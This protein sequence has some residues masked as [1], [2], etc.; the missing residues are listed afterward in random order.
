MNFLRVFFLD[1]GIVRKRR[2]NGVVKYLHLIPAHLQQ[3]LPVASG[4]PKERQDALCKILLHAEQFLVFNV[5][6][7]SLPFRQ[8]GRLAGNQDALKNPRLFFQRLFNHKLQ[9]RVARS[10]A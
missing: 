9:L 1:P 6:S 7:K 8:H 3:D 4:F 10:A 2:E 5:I